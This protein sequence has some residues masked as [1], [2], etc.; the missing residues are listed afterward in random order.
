MGVRGWVVKTRRVEGHDGV[1][2]RARCG[3]GRGGGG[4]T[5]DE[6]KGGEG[7]R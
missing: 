7:A 3:L 6:G 4:G 1:G 5:H 2:G